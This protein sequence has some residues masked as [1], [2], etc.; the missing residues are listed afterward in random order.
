[1]PESVPW[2]GAVATPASACDSDDDRRIN[3]R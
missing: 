2:E 1:M 3:R